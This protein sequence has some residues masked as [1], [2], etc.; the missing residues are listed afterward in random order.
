MC[1]M[2]VHPCNSSCRG[3]EDSG[4]DRGAIYLDREVGVN[5]GDSGD[6]IGTTL[7]SFGSHGGGEI[8]RAAI[9]HYKANNADYNEIVTLCPKAP[10]SP[11]YKGSQD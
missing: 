6:G 1:I 7:P 10:H 5:V 2:N 9:N 11:A 8:L 4:W 3:I